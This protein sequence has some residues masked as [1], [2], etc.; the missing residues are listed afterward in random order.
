MALVVHKLANEHQS[1]GPTALSWQREEMGTS[2]G[3]GWFL[4][5]LGFI[6]TT[7]R[8]ERMLTTPRLGCWWVTSL[9]GCFCC[10]E[11]WVCAVLLE[12]M[13]SKVLEKCEAVWRVYISVE[14]WGGKRNWHVP[15]VSCVPGTVLE[16][17]SRA[18]LALTAYGYAFS[19]CFP[20]GIW[21][22]LL[23]SLIS[24]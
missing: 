21:G 14:R 22:E 3:P 16:L 9:G 19:Q 13:C 5:L 18:C 11:I 15:S 6:S 2:H 7:P 4:S 20:W 10:F 24:A 1:L 8:M 23:C 17:S 12:R